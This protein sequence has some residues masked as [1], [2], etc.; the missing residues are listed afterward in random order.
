MIKQYFSNI[1]SKCYYQ[2]S[3]K[4]VILQVNFNPLS[5]NPT[6]WSNTLKQ[7]IHFWG[8]PLKNYERSIV[9]RSSGFTLKRI[10]CHNEDFDK[11]IV[12]HTIIKKY[13]NYSSIIKIKNYIPAKSHLN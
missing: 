3:F 5:T 6:E 4:Q 7:F 10:V 8:W 12:L 2:V 13:E 11:K 1:S 9:E